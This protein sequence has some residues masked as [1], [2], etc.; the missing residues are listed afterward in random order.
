M[1]NY[2]HPTAILGDNVTLGDNNYIGAYCIIGDPAE[3]KKYW[4]YE[5]QI[6]D[7]GTLK[8]IQKGQIKRGL[9]TIGNNNIITGLVTIDAGTEDE[10]TTIG[11]NNFIMKKVHIGHNAQVL[12]NCTIACNAIIGGHTIIN[13]NCNIGLGSIIHQNLIV[14]E[15]V[16]IG[17]GGIVT[18]KS[19][20]IPFNIYAGNPVK[21]LGLN[22]ILINL[23]EGDY[24]RHL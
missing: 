24:K 7:Y 16:M 9:V 11:N 15:F 19:K 5:E 14:P 13:N 12:S 17:M 21:C 20:L 6:K 4:E 18:K 10:S 1:A 22:K 8:I 2:I 3:H 23:Y